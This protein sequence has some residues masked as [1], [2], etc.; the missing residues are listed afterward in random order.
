YRGLGP[1]ESEHRVE[2]PRGRV[3]LDR[4]P[5]EH[6]SEREPN[7][8]GILS[9]LPETSDGIRPTPREFAARPPGEGLLEDEESE[10]DVHEDENGR[11]E[12]G[13]PRPEQPEQPS[14]RGTNHETG[15]G[16]GAHESE[17]LGPGLG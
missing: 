16:R 4:E 5:P 3:R 7:H 8:L 10:A 14:E 2:T 11:G 1:T 13:R 9:N 15:R 17:A 6:E 12:E